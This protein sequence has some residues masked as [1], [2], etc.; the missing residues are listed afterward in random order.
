M[1]SNR[2]VI[3][4]WAR[5]SRTLCHSMNSGTIDG[6]LLINSAETN[7]CTHVFIVVEYVFSFKNLVEAFWFVLINFTARYFWSWLLMGRMP[8][9]NL[10]SCVKV[11]GRKL[12]FSLVCVNVCVCV[13]LSVLGLL[14]SFYEIW[15]GNFAVHPNSVV[16]DVLPPVIGRS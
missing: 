9:F 10:L 1:R 16:L 13:V 12:K 2:A 8:V 11:R 4:F 3:S 15:Y 5:P 6:L 14:I 7:S